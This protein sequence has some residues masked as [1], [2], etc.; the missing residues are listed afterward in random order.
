[1]LDALRCGFSTAVESAVLFTSPLA[2]CKKDNTVTIHHAKIFKIFDVKV[3]FISPNDSDEK[4]RFFKCLYF[5]VDR[6]QSQS[7]R[8]GFAPASPGILGLSDC[9]S[10]E[11]FSLSV[12]L[13]G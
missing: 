3:S 7:S 10:I 5:V 12:L 6:S 13:P 4:P 11:R 9:S 8:A 1:M 2:R